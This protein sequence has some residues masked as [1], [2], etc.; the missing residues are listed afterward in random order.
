M[1]LVL[2]SNSSYKF[3]PDNKISE[4]T[5]RLPYTIDLSKGRW[6]VGLEEL[7]FYKSWYNVID[8]K[9]YVLHDDQK[10]TIHVP[11]GYYDS[12]QV[13][14]DQLNE[15]LDNQFPNNVK[16]TYNKLTRMCEFQVKLYLGVNVDMTFS[17]TLSEII[18]MKGQDFLCKFIKQG[19]SHV[20]ASCEKPVKLHSIFN[21]LIYSDIASETIVGD[22]ESSLLRNVVVEQDHWK[23]QCTNFNKVQY[24]PVAKQLINTITMYIYTD[25][26]ERVPFLD[27]RVVCTLDIRK[28]SPLLN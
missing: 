3:Y 5:V 8:A 13:L 21:I 2:P 19:Q 24:V 16:F 12:G 20:V 26:G 23:M 9:I 28:V 14:I 1:R 6:E 18:G 27:G 11:D 25:Y 4:Y 7:T 15:C 17:N 22:I 10:H